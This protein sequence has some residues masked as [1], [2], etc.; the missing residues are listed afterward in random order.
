MNTIF[1]VGANDGID[2]LILSF[3]NRKIQVFAFEPNPHLKKKIYHNKK[4]LEK[5]LK[6]KL[7]N[8]KLIEKAASNVN[9]KMDF[10]ITKNDA[11]SSLLK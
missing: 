9:K 11:T 7:I 1:D 4:K 3:L 6:T 2:G 10:Y 5:L 8:Y